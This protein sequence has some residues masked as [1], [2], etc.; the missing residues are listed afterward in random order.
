M[1]RVEWLDLPKETPSSTHA[2]NVTAAVN[3]IV[4]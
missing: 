3:A 1:N 2:A 4:Y